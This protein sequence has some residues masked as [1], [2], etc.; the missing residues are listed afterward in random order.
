MN[1][2]RLKLELTIFCQPKLI[3]SSADSLRHPL[4]STSEELLCPKRRPYEH[5]RRCPYGAPECPSQLAPY[6]HTIRRT[7]FHVLHLVHTKLSNVLVTYFYVPKNTYR[8]IRI[9]KTLPIPILLFLLKI[10]VACYSDGHRPVSTS[11][12]YQFVSLFYSFYSKPFSHHHTTDHTRSASTS[13]C[14]LPA[15]HN[16]AQPHHNSVGTYLTNPA[17]NHEIKGQV[18]VSVLI[19]AQ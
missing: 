15:H 7:P 11:F 16:P 19:A 3:L 9:L 17:P 13:T 14:N 10:A 4:L 2:P 18:Q 1:Q 8:N 12:S 5:V 6:G